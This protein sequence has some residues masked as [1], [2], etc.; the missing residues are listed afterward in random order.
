[1]AVSAKLYGLFFQSVFNKE[2]DIDSDVLKTMLCTSTYTPNQDTHRYKSDITN[3]VASGNGYTTGGNT[4]TGVT[5]SYNSTTNVL[6]F[7]GSNMSWPTST[8]VCRYGVVYD[9]SPST[10]AT[11]PLVG[12]VDFGQDMNPVNGTLSMTW[13]AGGI[14]TVTVS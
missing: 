14:A 7:T 10:D 6:S 11:R 4:I 8:F 9:S 12:Y 1:M 5:V 2:V 13:D 3:E